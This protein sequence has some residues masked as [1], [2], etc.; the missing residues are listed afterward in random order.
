MVGAL[1]PYTFLSS[2]GAHKQSS[3]PAI[4]VRSLAKQDEDFQEDT[5]YP[6]TSRLRYLQEYVINYDRLRQGPR[7][8]VP[9]KP[10][11]VSMSI[12]VGARWSIF[13]PRLVAAHEHAKRYTGLLKS[14]LKAPLAQY[15]PPFA[16]LI[17]PHYLVSLISVHR[18]ESCDRPC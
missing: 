13:G 15:S 9:T 14:V 1:W 3:S 17:L 11:E 12:A 5:E 16:R 7:P 8:G 4:Q 10:L 2:R 6:S 18:A